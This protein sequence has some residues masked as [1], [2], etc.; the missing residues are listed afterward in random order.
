MVG[1]GLCVTLNMKMDGGQWI[2]CHLGHENGC[3]DTD[4]V[5]PGA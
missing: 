2:V 3:C 5:L 1:H 4:C